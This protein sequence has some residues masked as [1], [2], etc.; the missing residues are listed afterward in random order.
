MKGGQL[1][2]YQW[3]SKSLGGREAVSTPSHP[4]HSLSICPSQGLC[5]LLKIMHL[6]SGAPLTF[7]AKANPSVT[8]SEGTFLFQPPGEARA[9]HYDL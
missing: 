2:L 5:H 6:E 7:S 3:S 4:Y 1:D 9:P 8:F